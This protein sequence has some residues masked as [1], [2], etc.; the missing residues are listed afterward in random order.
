[1]IFEEDVIPLSRREVAT[2]RRRVSWVL[3]PRRVVQTEVEFG[4]K[5][6][7]PRLA[8]VENAGGHE[9]LKV[10][11]VRDHGDWDVRA[12]DPGSH[13]TEGLHDSE[14]LLVVDFVVDFRWR[15]LAG[16]EGDWV[17]ETVRVGLMKDV[18]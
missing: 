10:F 11:V 8:A 5:H 3:E 16:E 9:I 2:P 13:V 15:E 4:E 17:E 18:L 14:E 6:R 12:N 7:P 1:M